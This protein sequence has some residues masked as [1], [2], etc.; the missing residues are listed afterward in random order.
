MNNN[1]IEIRPSQ[2]LYVTD[3]DGTLLGNDH[4]L[5]QESIGI[6]NPLIAQGLNLMV[7]TARNF[8]SAS[9]LLSQVDLRSP[10]ILAN[11][12]LIADNSGVPIWQ[13]TMEPSLLLRIYNALESFA[14]ACVWT[15]LKDGNFLLI[16]HDPTPEVIRF[17]DYRQQ[18][19]FSGFKQSGGLDHLLQES[20][21][22]LTLMVDQAIAQQALMTLE[23]AG[24]L[25]ELRAHVMPYPGLDGLFTMTVQPETIHKGA[26]IAAYLEMVADV[27]G[28]PI[29]RIVVFG[30]ERNDLTMFELAHVSLAVAEAHPQVKA[31]ATAVIG[32][33]DE[34]AVAKWLREDFYAQRSNTSC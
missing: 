27:Q 16:H 13:A 5:S 19:G 14:N 11:G 7:A 18:T 8:A 2:T 24:L 9:D 21:I 15:S 1:R 26:A 32:S 28:E 33:N 30:D 25:T 10:M 20:I 17:Q 22:T 4:Q 6:L 34:S 29:N 31:A 23:T 3:L 12:A